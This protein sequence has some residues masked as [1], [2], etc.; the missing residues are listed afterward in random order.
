MDI[1]AAFQEVGEGIGQEI[2][3]LSVFV[4]CFCFWKHLQSRFKRSSLNRTAAAGQ[5]LTTRRK[6]AEPEEVLLDSATKQRVE[7]G[8]AQIMRLLNLREFTSALNMYRSF[9]REGLDGHLATEAMYDSFIQSA[10]RVGKIDV[11]ERMLH[12]MMRN[13]V[14][15]KPSFWNSTLKLLS[16][17][18]HFPCCLHIF[19]TYG[20]ILPN[21]KVIF[22]CL[23]NAALEHG[24]QEQ[25]VAMVRRYKQCDLEICDYV[26]IFRTY[27]SAGKLEQAER[28]FKE[29]QGKTS[30]LM[31][32]LLL[33]TA[34]KC[35]EPERALQLLFEGHSYDDLDAPRI[36]DAISYNT[37]IK[38]FVVAGN[39]QQCFECLK[40]MQLHKL[41]PDDVTLTTLFQICIAQKNRN[42]IDHVVSMMNAEGR[43]LDTGTCNLFI[44][45]LIHAARLPKAV[46]IY[47]ALKSSPDRR[48]KPTIVTYSMLIRAY[49]DVQDLEQALLVFQDMNTN[50][51]APDEMIF[52]HLF[53]GC[54]AA[55]NF[56][57]GEQLFQDMLASG[58]KPSEYTLTMMLKLHGRCGNLEKAYHLV[59]DWESLY[60]NR[61]SVIHYTCLMTGCLR[62][63]QYDQAWAAF[64]LMQKH[65]VTSDRT[66]ISTLLPA[67]VTSQKF[68]RVLDLSRYALK[69]FGNADWL[70]EILSSVTSKMKRF[71][72]RE[73]YLTQLRGL[74]KTDGVTVHA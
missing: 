15:P 66:M 63:R 64:E 73:E 40:Q 1:A 12:L 28:L 70:A 43:T 55:G 24:S 56:P 53:E 74:L 23:I 46:E 25:A 69:A 52:T 37:V 31:M 8:G 22:S 35:N 44:K 10:T 9:E 36:V 16:S 48:S 39:I 42:G 32:N 62:S 5:K 30:T 60:R 41:Q 21:D 29:L 71:Q 45:G 57:L 59:A 50:G 17:R 3:T 4:V 38:G 13:G 47:E 20:H 33:H 68:D 49:V 67:M 54:R 61:P 7:D 72:C 65:R 6:S 2:A 58:V 14:T 34:V 51:D 11:V 26:T 19:T 27:A 18:K